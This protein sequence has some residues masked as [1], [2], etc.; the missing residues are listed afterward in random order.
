MRSNIW[1]VDPEGRSFVEAAR[2]TQIVGC[3]IETIAELGYGQASLAKIAA[4]AGIS[5]GVISYH[6]KGK[7]DLLHEVAAEVLGAAEA[8][9]GPR[10]LAE[11]GAAAMLRAYIESSLEFMATHRQH[12]LALMEIVTNHRTGLPAPFVAAYQSGLAMLETHMREG[13]RT[14]EFREFSTGVMAATIRAAI[15]AVPAQMAAD[16][17]LDL[18]AYADELATSIDLA[19]RKS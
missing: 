15:D 2:R 5:K 7:D 6:F 12:T 13:Q 1:A 9:M 16:P 19:V 18:A 14:G 8:F 4:R 10:I 17:G 3:A 11:A